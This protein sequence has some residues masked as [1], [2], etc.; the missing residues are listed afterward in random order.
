[1]SD[2]FNFTAGTGLVGAA[3]DRSGVLHQIIIEA[4]V[5]GGGQGSKVSTTPGTAVALSAI[6]VP[7]KWV[8]V[9]GFEG[10]ADSVVIGFSNAVRAG[11]TGGAPS[12]T[13]TGLVLGA[14][15]NEELKVSNLNLLYLD[16]ITSGDGV[17]FLYG[18]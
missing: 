16:V 18:N 3:E 5:A 14:N 10:N 11:A 1:M 2:N 13:R 12:G 8:R 7:C 6:S 15:Q 4:G 9:C 17:H